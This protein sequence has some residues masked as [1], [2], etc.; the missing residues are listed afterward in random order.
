MYMNENGALCYGAG[1]TTEE[2]CPVC[3]SDQIEDTDR[4]EHDGDEYMGYGFACPVCG[5][6][7]YKNYIRVFDGYVVTE[8]PTKPSDVILSKENTKKL[9]DS[10]GQI[11]AE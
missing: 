8:I 10:I 6:G 9:S 1:E 4:E 2:T 7:G 11:I 3:G 5:A